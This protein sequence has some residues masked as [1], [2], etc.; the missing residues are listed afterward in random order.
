MKG[1]WEF[2]FS[3]RT[4][5]P[6]V[7][8]APGGSVSVPIT[9]DMRGQQQPVTLNI[10]TNWGSAGIVAQVV[11]GV[12]AAGGG[13][14]LHVVVSAATPPGSYIFGIQGATSGTFK[15]S[16]AMVTVVVTPTPAE[17]D[18]KPEG[19]GGGQPSDENQGP[20]TKGHKPSAK[21]VYGK[22]AAAPARRGPAGFLMT[23]VMLGSLG[24]GFYYLDQQFGLIDAIFG[25][26]SSTGETGGVTTY[27]GTQTFTIYSAMGGSPNSA[28]G[29]VSIQINSSGD[30]LGPVLFGKIT[31]GVFTG[32]AHAQDGT[33]F[34]MNGTFSGG[35]LK[36][37]YKSGSVSWVWNLHQR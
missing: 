15:T 5:S 18:R 33:V 8:A 28:T 12:I 3:V 1:A 21:P 17:Q 23:L 36:A 2:D 29:P 32:E 4:P 26:S 27:E 7:T 24:F 34:P 10:A 16:E 20:V 25:T 22:M 19:T 11:P 35:I 31:N 30:V 6:I 9:V 37:E 13:A 14:T